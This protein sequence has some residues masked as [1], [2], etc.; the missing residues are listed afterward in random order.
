MRYVAPIAEC[1]ELEN[2]NVI[3]ASAE[4]EETTVAGNEGGGANDGEWD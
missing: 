4:A 1:V 3:L 2:V